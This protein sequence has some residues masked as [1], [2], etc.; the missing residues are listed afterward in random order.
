MA[1]QQHAEVA[2]DLGEE[3]VGQEVHQDQDLDLDQAGE[4]YQNLK[5]RQ[6][7]DLQRPQQDSGRRKEHFPSVRCVCSR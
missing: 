5:N 1:A 7:G 6:Q 4:D 2:V 3:E